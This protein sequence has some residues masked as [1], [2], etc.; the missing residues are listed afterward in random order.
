MF[1]SQITQVPT[2]LLNLW[3]ACN[4]CSN[5]LSSSIE[6]VFS[7]VFNFS[8]T[9]SWTMQRLRNKWAMACSCSASSTRSGLVVKTDLRIQRYKRGGWSSIRSI[10]WTLF[11]ANAKELHTFSSVY[12]VSVL[13]MLKRCCLHHFYFTKALR[14]FPKLSIFHANP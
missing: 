6:K 5:D 10:L 13:R 3:E 2:H 12:S 14:V 1:V 8:S 9:A 7:K 4:S 11:F